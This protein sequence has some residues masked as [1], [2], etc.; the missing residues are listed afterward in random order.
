MNVVSCAVAAFPCPP[1]SQTAIES[2]DPATWGVTPDAVLSVFSWGF[3]AV[4]MMWLIG[5]SLGAIITTLK[6]I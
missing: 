2:L 3:G 5:F 6:K 1:E 4:L